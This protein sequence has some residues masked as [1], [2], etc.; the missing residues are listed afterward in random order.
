MAY[1]Q[2]LANRI[3][4]LLKSHPDIIEKKLFGGVGF[5]LH[6][7]MACGI[8]RN[9]LIIR[10]EPENQAALLAQ[11]HVRAFTMRAGNPMKGWIQVT[12][13]GIAS[14]ADLHKWVEIGYKYASSLPA[15]L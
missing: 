13:E 3:R 1:D 14:D 12:S 4:N 9:E 2:D 10:V 8:L 6:G 11:T 7:N 15:K 5:I